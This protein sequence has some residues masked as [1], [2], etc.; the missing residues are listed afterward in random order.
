MFYLARRTGRKGTEFRLVKFR[1]MVPDADRMGGG[2]TL[3]SDR[4]VTRVGRFLRKLK[5]DE[6]PQLWNVLKGEM[7]LVG[8]RPEDPRYVA[9]YGP[10]QRRILLYAPGITSPASLEY[11]DEEA[12]LSGPD[13][14]EKYLMNVLPHKIALD[15]AYFQ[16]R[17][18]RG[19]LRLIGMTIAS[20]VR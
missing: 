5:L 3:T 11:R 15:L 6:F 9:M 16:Q 17:T 2:L 19:D 4:R 8:P 10:E 18:L 7:S 13:W 20:I 1:T 14:Q 12:L